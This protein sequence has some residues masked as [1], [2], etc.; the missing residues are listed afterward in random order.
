[1]MAR[2]GNQNVFERVHDKAT[3][4]WIVGVLLLLGVAATGFLYA[5][6]DSTEY[7]IRAE[8]AALREVV[9]ANGKSLARI[10]AVLAAGSPAE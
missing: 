4:H 6:I 10:E 8:I 1:M 7:E 2:D 9:V 5:K 3:I